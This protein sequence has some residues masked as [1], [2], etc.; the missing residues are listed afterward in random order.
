MPPLDNDSNPCYVSSA[1]AISRS[2]EDNT[3]TFSTPTILV[4]NGQDG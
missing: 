3:L 4:K 2:D 1:V